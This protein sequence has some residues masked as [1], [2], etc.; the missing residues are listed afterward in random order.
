MPT[1]RKTRRIQIQPSDQPTHLGIHAPSAVNAPSKTARQASALSAALGLGQQVAGDQ[2]QQRQAEDAEDGALAAMRGDFSDEEL[3]KMEK[4]AAF[5]TSAQKVLAKQRIIEDATAAREWYQ[6]E[7]DKNAGLDDLRAGLNQFWETR[8]AGVS[9][10]IAREIV[11]LMSQ[12]SDEIIKS[13]ARY[14]EEQTHTELVTAQGMVLDQ[15]LRAGT[16]DHDAV[17]GEASA[18]LGKDAANALIT[19]R[20][21]E[22]AISMNDETILD[23]NDLNTLRQNRKYAP[24]IASAR[25]NIEKARIAANEEATINT[26]GQIAARIGEAAD[27]GS[28]D[29][30]S[31]MEQYTTPDPVTGVAIIE[32]DDQARGLWTRY[33]RSFG[34]DAK[35][36]IHKAN[37]L[38]GL[39]RR[40]AKRADR[41]Q[42]AADAINEIANRE[43]PEAAEAVLIERSVINNELPAFAKAEI[44][45]APTNPAFRKAVDLF[46]KFEAYNKGWI[47][48][49]INSDTVRDILYYQR[50]R[51]DHGEERAIELLDSYD[52]KLFE[53]SGGTRAVNE[54][55][56]TIID[57]IDGNNVSNLF[58]G[59]HLED[60]AVLRSM[61]HDDMKYYVNQ[62]RSLD[63]ALKLTAVNLNPE[64]GRYVNVDGHLY[65]NTDGWNSD[66]PEVAELTRTEFA[67][68]LG[69]TKWYSSEGDGDEIEIV[70]VLNRPGFVRIGHKNDVIKYE[71]RSIAEL[72]ERFLQVRAE[73]EAEII[74]QGDEKT[75]RELDEKAKD[76]YMPLPSYVGTPDPAMVDIMRAAREEQWDDLPEQE[77]QRLRDRVR[78][79]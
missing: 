23:H 8:Y 24:K 59:N 5:V 41:E 22:Y 57:I 58:S 44:E 47:G 52:P 55:I 12:T 40:S 76:L 29:F 50:L 21:I 13:H 36:D 53:Q 19:E 18:L 64:S 69:E 16:Y 54:V 14:Q 48:S 79:N 9:T 38:A 10:G 60:S 3:H 31:L 32:T 77:R 2:I 43:G 15:A 61:I 68:E 71:I 39:A 66:A 63:E 20:W 49:Q 17:R 73:N 27:L 26:Q 65:K 25:N 51:E 46:E 42:G 1:R 56:P 11:P 72:N 62:G 78:S 30:P 45:I 67:K 70:P 28:T 74:R 35:S 33:F 75:R 34:E 6:Q 4:S 37:W 7:F